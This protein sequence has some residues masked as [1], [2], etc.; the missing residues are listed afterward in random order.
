MGSVASADVCSI[1]DLYAYN[2]LRGW[3]EWVVNST[4]DLDA[5]PANC[6]TLVD[7]S[8]TIGANFSGTF[9]LKGVQNI[10]SKSFHSLKYCDT[11]RG[12]SGAWK[13]L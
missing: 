10:T 12:Y 11:T 9:S 2:P 3:P 5:L 13:Y 6:T 1:A 4:S 8:I 7:G